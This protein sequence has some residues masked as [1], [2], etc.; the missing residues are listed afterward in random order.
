MRELVNHEKFGMIEYTENFWTGRKNLYINGKQLKKIRRGTYEWQKE[1]GTTEFC[2]LGGNFLKGVTLMIKSDTIPLVE[3]IRWY[4]SLMAFFLAI[5]P[6]VWGSVRSLCLIIPIVGGAVG[7]AVYFT[8]A[9]IA[10]VIIKKT[11]NLALKFL[12]WFAALVVAFVVGF[13]IVLLVI[14]VL[15]RAQD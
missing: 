8:V 10:M 12:I 1:D 9:F 7:G 13:L 3:P 14:D 5:I 11:N 4:E 2:Y 15:L 6:M